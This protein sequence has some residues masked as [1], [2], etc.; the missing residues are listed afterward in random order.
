MFNEN[1]KEYNGVIYCFTNK[2]NGKKYIGQTMAF[3]KTRIGQHLSESRKENPTLAFHKALKKYT[4]DNFDIKI[5]EKLIANSR[6]ELKTMLNEREIYYI[7]LYSSTVDK[8]GYNLTNGG[9]TTYLTAAIPLYQ[10]THEGVFI[11][12]YNSHSLAAIDMN[13]DPNN[14]SSLTNCA[15]HETPQAYGYIWEYTDVCNRIY[16]KPEKDCSFNFKKAKAYTLDGELVGIFNSYKEASEFA[17]IPSPSISEAIDKENRTAGGYIW[18]SE[19]KDFS[20]LIELPRIR[21]LKKPI[22]AYTQDGKFINTF[23]H[24]HDIQQFLGT[25][26]KIN[27]IFTVANGIRTKAYG[28]KWFYADDPNQ[29]DK[30]KIIINSEEETDVKAF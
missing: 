11:K 14:I 10:F 30:T 29:P 26:K 25:P 4:I 7:S 8:N 24:G 9:E 15:R 20:P 12:K 18:R 16:I 17:G 3:L 19:N 21:D 6:E 28:F 22:S 2:I 23:Y 13:G 27:N 1:T 5:L